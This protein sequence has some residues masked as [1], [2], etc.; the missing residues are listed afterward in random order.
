M[1]VEAD[2]WDR[3]RELISRSKDQQ[4]DEDALS[5]AHLAVKDVLVD[6][7]DSRMFVIGRANGF[8]INE[9]DGQSSSIIRLGTRDGLRIAIK[10]YLE[11]LT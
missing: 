7:R 2:G 8:V 9:A 5:V 3:I 4:L 6:M 11:A 10:A 1:A